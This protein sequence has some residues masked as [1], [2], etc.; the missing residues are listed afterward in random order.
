MSQ[1]AKQDKKTR[2]PSRISKWI[3]R[4]KPL[5]IVMAYIFIILTVNTG[6]PTIFNVF[7]ILP[8]IALI[9]LFFSYKAGSIILVSLLFCIYYINEFV[10]SSRGRPISFMDI[11]SIKDALNVAANYSSY[12]NLSILIHLA[13][14]I[15]L[16][17]VL[18][19]FLKDLD[20]DPKKEKP[21]RVKA[22]CISLLVSIPVYALLFF[23]NI[24]NVKNPDYYEGHY[25]F[26][27]GYFFAWYSEYRQSKLTPPKDYD[28]DATKWYLV[29]TENVPEDPADQPDNII[30]IMNEALTD[31]SLSYD[32]TYN[33]DPLPFI[34]SLDKNCVKGRLHVNIY[35]GNTSN[36][37]YEFLTGNSL[38]F[39]PMNTIPYLQHDLT[40]T[41]SIIKDLSGWNNTAIHPYFRTGYKRD[42]V[43]DALGFDTFISGEDLAKAS[44]EDEV[45]KKDIYL[46]IIIGIV[47]KFGDKYKY[48]RDFISDETCYDI[49]QQ[50]LQGN[51]GKDFVFLV[52]IQNHAGYFTKY[53]TA[54]DFVDNN[55]GQEEQYLNLIRESDTAFKKMIDEHSKN[56]K[57]TV[58]IMFGD[59]QPGIYYDKFTVSRTDDEYEKRAAQYSVPYI[60][61]SNYEMD[62]DIPEDLSVNY[63]SA[64]V[65]ANCGLG[66]TQYDR[67]RLE[68]AHEFPVLTYNYSMDSTGRYMDTKEALENKKVRD[69]QAV[70]YYMNH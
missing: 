9:Y 6:T 16:T 46:D 27:N 52:T 2:E 62:W 10:N 35:G 54:I 1:I 58:V 8:V 56:D 33:E 18:F 50:Y 19:N 44:G 13:I 36:T 69:Y 42:I 23:T 45:N 47:Q 43:Y 37:E 26:S 49:T 28:E 39:M 63:L 11:Y 70:Q 48:I 7:L 67:V 15:F 20:Y 14:D 57:K 12:I 24:V 25:M 32:V 64:Y 34:H 29:S 66:L 61:W 55:N 65:K 40:N 22:S 53:D 38:A 41:P 3:N 4:H 68:A 31:Y 5:V 17:V 51:N 59:H 21:L 60:I 30:V